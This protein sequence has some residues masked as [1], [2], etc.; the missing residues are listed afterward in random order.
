MKYIFNAKPGERFF[1]ASDIGW[2]CVIALNCEI[3]PF[4]EIVPPHSPC[5]FC[6]FAKVVG[7]SFIVYGWFS[8]GIPA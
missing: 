7:H 6:S 8:S 4:T 2:V 5:F 1:A 3:N